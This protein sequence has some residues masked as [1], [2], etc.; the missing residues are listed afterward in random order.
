MDEISRI[1]ESLVTRIQRLRSEEERH[2]LRHTTAL[3][4]LADIFNNKT[5]DMPMMNNPTHQTST[6]ST[7]PAIIKTAPRVNQHTTRVNTPCMLPPYARVIIPPT[8]RATTPPT[9]P[10]EKSYTHQIDMSPQGVNGQEQ[11]QERH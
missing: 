11:G 8:S 3:A 5:D 9:E 6:Q 2:P 7:E 1:A 4:K 10:A